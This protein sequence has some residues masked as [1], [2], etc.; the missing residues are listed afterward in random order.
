VNATAPLFEV[1]DTVIARP[2]RS[3]AHPV[4]EATE[5]DLTGIA[6][7]ALWGE[8]LDRSVSSQRQTV[9]YCA[10]SGPAATPAASAT[11][12]SSRPSSPA[13]TSSRTARSFPARRPRPFAV[14]TRCRRERRCGASSPARISGG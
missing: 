5:D 11:G 10:R 4:I 14:S 6:G 3:V 7:V 9:G 13:E 8:L 12:R 1:D 2:I